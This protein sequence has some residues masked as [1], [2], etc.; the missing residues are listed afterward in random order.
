M[1]TQY[2]HTQFGT[3]IVLP[4]IASIILISILRYFIGPSFV[5]AR[6]LILVFLVCI[7]LFYSL[8]VE[9]SNG[10]LKIRFGI[11]LIR[12]KFLIKDIEKAFPVKNQWYCGWGIHMTRN[13]W[14]F[15]V[16]GF[17]AVE[18][19]MSSGK[20]YRIGT[21]QPEDLTRAIDEARKLI[22]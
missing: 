7:A 8:I 17:D 6:A 20:H 13:G 12:K 21:D 10:F 2:Q 3:Y 22:T 15:N 19:V 1:I 16:S 11:G 9:I 5:V 4:L 14:L 18:I